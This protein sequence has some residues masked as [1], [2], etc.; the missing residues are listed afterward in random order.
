MAVA[1]SYSLAPDGVNE[2]LVVET[3]NKCL[4]HNPFHKQSYLLFVQN[5]LKC[6]FVLRFKI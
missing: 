4:A 3:M 2:Q 1:C 5:R 6:N